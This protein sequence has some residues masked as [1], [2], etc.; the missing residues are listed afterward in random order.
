L[1]QSRNHSLT[2][3]GRE[4]TPAPVEYTPEPWRILEGSTDNAWT[5]VGESQTRGKFQI[6]RI[7]DAPTVEECQA[8]ARLIAQAP[9][10]HRAAVKLM[11]LWGTDDAQ[12]AMDELAE[13][14]SKAVRI[15][16]GARAKR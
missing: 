11:C 9:A 12:E 15:T 2:I 3:V 6:A 14:V 5:I 8:N 16:G 13:V 7:P 4:E 1:R 10:M